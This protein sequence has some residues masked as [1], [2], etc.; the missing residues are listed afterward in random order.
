MTGNITKASRCSDRGDTAAVERRR[1]GR[2]GDSLTVDH[3]GL[4]G[5]VRQGGAHYQPAHSNALRDRLIVVAVAAGAITSSGSALV[6]Q[7]ADASGE[8]IDLIAHQDPISPAAPGPSLSAPTQPEALAP[9]PGAT[10]PILP[11][12]DLATDG[13][14]AMVASL[15]AGTALDEQRQI[16]AEGARLAEEQARRPR[17]AMPAVGS[18]TSGFGQ[19]WGSLHGGADIANAI[20]TPIL[21]ASDGMVIDAGPAQGFGNWVRIM[22]DEG[23]MTVYGHMEEVLVTTGQRVQA[24]QTIALMGNRGFSTGSHL[25]FEVWTNGGR[26]R[27]DPL[28]WLRHQGID[29]DSNTSIA[30]YS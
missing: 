24:G 26:D 28:E 11:L 25:H 20:G 14:G 3:W 10:E 2:G 16:A 30:P 29:P 22:S 27:A 1:A 6:T 17:A 23:T 9:Q 13:A 15:M 4:A 21:A 8:H 12:D 7:H 5:P 18:L 19:R